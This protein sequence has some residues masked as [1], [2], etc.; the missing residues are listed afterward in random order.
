M[1]SKVYIL[2]RLAKYGGP[3]TFRSKFESFLES[4]NLLANSLQIFGAQDRERPSILIVNG[5]RKIFTQALCRLLGYSI[6]LRLDGAIKYEFSHADSLKSFF[7]VHVRF[8]IVTI[9]AL[10]SQKIIYQ[11][12]HIRDTHLHSRFSKVIF[13]RKDFRIIHNPAVSGV[14]KSDKGKKIL[15]VEGR[16]GNNYSNYLL[17]RL[18]QYEQIVVIGNV[19]KELNIKSIEYRGS[20]AHKEV[21]NVFSQPWKAVFVLEA[22]PPCPNSVLEAIS[23]GIPVIGVNNG[24]LYEILGDRKLLISS[25]VHW[26]DDIDSIQ[27][28]DGDIEEVLNYVDLNWDSISNNM[29]RRS[30]K[31]NERS[32]F[33]RYVN[34]II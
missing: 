7:M 4:N 18:A 11:S 6:T 32:I 30:E 27:V 10:L 17:Q 16:T 12:A 33:M 14:D 24:S 23:Y 19:D 1:S 20:I 28:A 3:F 2:G 26:G 9:N 5:T 21:L 31:F 25:N 13:S 8:V 29:V 22:F 15:C 34:F